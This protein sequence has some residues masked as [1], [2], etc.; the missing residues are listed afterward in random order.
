MDRGMDCRTESVVTSM[1]KRKPVAIFK[2]ICLFYRNWTVLLGPFGFQVSHLK[3]DTFAQRRRREMFLRPYILDSV[4]CPTSHRSE[5]VAVALTAAGSGNHWGLWEP[6]LPCNTRGPF[7]RRHGGSR[8]LYFKAECSSPAFQKPK[9]P[10]SWEYPV[11]LFIQRTAS[12][13]STTELSHPLHL[14][15]KPQWEK[16]FPERLVTEWTG[17]G[18]CISSGTSLHLY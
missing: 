7:W 13:A 5:V 10:D 2:N 16:H 18:K 15:L 3:S 11:A 14:L 4:S 6:Q 8:D 17:P 1:K 9:A 12:C